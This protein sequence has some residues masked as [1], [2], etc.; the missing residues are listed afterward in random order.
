[1]SLAQTVVFLIRVASIAVFTSYFF[2]GSAGTHNPTSMKILFVMVV[3][4]T[5]TVSAGSFHRRTDFPK[6][7]NNKVRIRVLGA[8]FFSTPFSSIGA[9]GPV[10]LEH[11]MGR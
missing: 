4:P 7:R 5:L 11:F 2:S 3:T 9:V 10:F 6:E 1:M 8:N